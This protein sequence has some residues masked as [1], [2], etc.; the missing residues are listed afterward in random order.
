[1]VRGI[2]RIFVVLVVVAMLGA[3]GFFIWA[4]QPA[5]ARISPPV[6]SDFNKTKIA[7]GAILASM[8]YCAECH[9]A[10]GGQPFAGGY[11]VPTPFG[12]IYGS[13]I[14][15]DP[16]TG[17]GNWSE[18]AFVRAMHKG[19]ARDGA[20]LYP[21]FPYNHFT[22]IS[23]EDAEA[24]YA[25]LMTRQ[26]VR[27][28][29]QPPKLPFPLDI[30]M[31]MAGWNL[32]FLYTGGFRPDP[33]QSATWNRGAYIAEG[34]GHCAACHTP[35][36]IL[37]AEIADSQYAGGYNEGWLAPALNRSSSAPAPWTKGELAAY[38][39]NSF[40]QT[41]GMAAGPMAGVTEDLQTLPKS[42]LNAL[43][44]YIASFE[45]PP[46]AAKT[47]QA[48]GAANKI[49]YYITTAQQINHQGSATTGEAIF[50]GACA[51]CHFQ[52]GDQPFYRPVML[53][54]SSV[55]HV[56]SPE[57]FIEIVLHGVQPPP[58]A[59]GRWMP[60]F[61]GALTQ[62]QI[63]LLAQYVRSHFTDEPAWTNIEQTVAQIDKGAGQ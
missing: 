45:P 5:I 46:S 63:V 61:G 18:A 16:Q 12:T 10:Q 59:Q 40:V 8:G 34:L 30:R 26:P 58:G 52:G 6:P 32:L 43:A 47:T 3:I 38:L 37:G 27:N 44:T 28:A 22:L 49:A 21:A 24:I 7:K 41:H 62:S 50:A 57:N 23:N 51:S 1:M 53:G 54:F 19:I 33:N 13:N 35:H 9:T 17:I 15:P 29:V 48:V 11:P 4:K 39:G 20:H 31:V 2:L 25:Y 42:D 60:P 56:P 36:N 14:T 55:T